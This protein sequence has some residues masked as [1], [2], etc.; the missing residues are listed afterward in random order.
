MISSVSIV[1][2]HVHL[3]NP[4]RTRMSWLDGDELLNRAYLMEEYRE[5][6]KDLPIEAMVFMECGVEPQYAFLE[7]QW[8]V[9]YARQ[10][11]RL[12]GIVAAAPVEFG[13]RAQA[14]LE[15]LAGLGPLV[16]G[17]RR[18]IQDETDGNFCLQP[19]FI[20]GV[21]LASAR[22]F[23]FDLCIRHT[24]LPAVTELVRRCPDTQFMLDHLGKPPARA[25]ILDP[26]RQHIRELA[27]LPNVYCKVSGLVTEAD[28]ATWDTESLA[29]YIEH[30]WA[31]FG[32]ERV[33]FA[34]DWPV[35]LSASTYKRW[36]G[37][38]QTLATSL[39]PTAQHKFWH[40]NARRFYRLDAASIP[41]A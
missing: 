1:D 15:A 29:P 10:H 21:Q 27:A 22:Q 23:T 18:N 40:E 4:V 11:S 19:A 37:T 9:Q 14:Y 6:T 8:A 2:A 36:V 5:S 16:K 38:L 34:G 31:T 25:R 24:Q 3:W 26:W 20:Q 39:S 13:S 32:E 28:P 7:A 33:V 12:Q 17:V 41:N 30:V 35:M